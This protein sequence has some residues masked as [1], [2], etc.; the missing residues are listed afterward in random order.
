MTLEEIVKTKKFAN[1]LQK[2]HINVLVTASC[3]RSQFNNSLKPFGITHEQYNVLRI[4]RGSAPT[5]LCMKEIQ[6]RMIDKSSNVSRIVDRMLE[7]EIAEKSQSEMDKRENLVKITGKG[8]ELLDEI[9]KEDLVNEGENPFVGISELECQMLN[10][11]L[12]KFRSA[13]YERSTRC[14]PEP[15]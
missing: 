7:K 1:E 11:L 4:L 15:S 6:C 9:H 8:L 10:A 5:G 13:A 14:T 2:A 3:L 12:E